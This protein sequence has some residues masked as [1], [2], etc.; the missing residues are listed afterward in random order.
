MANR[1]AFKIRITHETFDGFRVPIRTGEL[2]E[3][4]AAHWKPQPSISREALNF[5]REAFVPQYSVSPERDA[6]D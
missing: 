6:N 5:A 1:S 3:Q 4:L 2:P